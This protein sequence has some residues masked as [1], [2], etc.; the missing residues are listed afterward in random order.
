MARNITGNN[1]TKNSLSPLFKK[2]TKLFS[3]PIVNYN[4]QYQRAF[5]R[6]QLDKFD[7]RH[8]GFTSLH[9]LMV[10]NEPEDFFYDRTL[11][12]YFSN[13]EIDVSRYLG[14][15]KTPRQ[16]IFNFLVDCDPT[17]NKENLTWLLR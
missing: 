8:E 9:K 16:V 15:E 2:L 13:R 12:T 11:W 10:Y 5:R 4:Q 3:G 6:N 7:S 17:P 1:N 14:E